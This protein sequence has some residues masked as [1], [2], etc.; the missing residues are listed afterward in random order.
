M[1]YRP[2]RLH[3]CDRCKFELTISVDD[4]SSVIPRL[5]PIGKEPPHPATLAC[6]ICYAE[7]IVKNCGILRPVRADA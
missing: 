2:P 7:F 1:S 4:S 5:L 6:P 3:R